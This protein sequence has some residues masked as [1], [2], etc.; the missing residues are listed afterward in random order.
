[1][2]FNSPTV[3]ELNEF[4]SHLL[5]SEVT[6]SGNNEIYLKVE[7]DHGKL[8]EIFAKMEDGIVTDISADYEGVSVEDMDEFREGRIVRCLK[9]KLRWDY[10]LQL[11][12]KE[13]NI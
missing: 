4:S 2:I 12:E 8:H 10:E 7:D 11:L 6:F 9:Q 3:R 5:K 1:M 13:E